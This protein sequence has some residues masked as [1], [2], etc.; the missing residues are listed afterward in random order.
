MRRSELEVW[1]EGWGGRLLI[2]WK[3]MERGGG[4]DLGV[5]WG[6]VVFVIREHVG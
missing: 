4:M 3:E 1:G 5:V 2:W 6:P